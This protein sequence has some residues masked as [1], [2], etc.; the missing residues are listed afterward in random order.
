MEAEVKSLVKQHIAEL[1]SFDKDTFDE[2]HDFFYKSFVEHFPW[3]PSLSI[4]RQVGLIILSFTLGFKN[5]LALTNILE[6]IETG[7]YISAAEELLIAGYHQVS[8]MI[9]SSDSPKSP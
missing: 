8:E 9:H 1:P 3:F 4:L 2:S 5:V 7:K 6:L